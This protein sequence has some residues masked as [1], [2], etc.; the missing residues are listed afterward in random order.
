MSGVALKVLHLPFLHL[1]VESCLPLAVP[2][3][4]FVIGICTVHCAL[5]EQGNRAG[6]VA[7]P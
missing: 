6:N 7:K 2:M 4:H 5:V 3:L 1:L